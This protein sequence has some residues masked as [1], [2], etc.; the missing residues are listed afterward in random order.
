MPIRLLCVLAGSASEPSPPPRPPTP[1]PPPA[2]R[3]C[4]AVRA[5][6]QPGAIGAFTQQSGK[7]PAVF[8]YF[9]S[10]GERVDFHWLGL[11]LEDAERA[12]SH[13]MLSVVARGHRPLARATSPAAAATAF[14]VGLNRLSPSTDRSSTCARCR[15]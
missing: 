11:R 7:H 12:N 6:T 15:R 4:G 8:N 2:T 3:F 1:T 14:L 13:A 10:W 9:I 5:A